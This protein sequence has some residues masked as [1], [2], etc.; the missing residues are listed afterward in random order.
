ML[1]L[2]DL[3]VEGITTIASSVSYILETPQVDTLY[4]ASMAI[5]I[6][7]IGVYFVW[8][9]L[10]MLSEFDYQ[11][12]PWLKIIKDVL[13]AFLFLFS[14]P[15][16]FDVVLEMTTVILEGLNNMGEVSV[17]MGGQLL[18]ISISSSEISG[19]KEC[20]AKVTDPNSSMYWLND[21]FN[22]TQACGTGSDTTRW[23][24]DYIQYWI[25][26][27]FGAVNLG[28][29]LVCSITAAVNS[30]YLMVFY[31]IAP[32]W[33][34]DLLTNDKQRFK[35]WKQYT[36][37]YTFATGLMIFALNIGLLFVSSFLDGDSGTSWFVL[38]PML[39][40]VLIFAL[41]SGK[42]LGQFFGS[43]ASAAAGFQAIT[44]MIST[45]GSIA[46]APGNI[47]SG[48]GHAAVGAAVLGAATAG[49]ATNSVSSGA[50]GARAGISAT[51]GADSP[52]SGFGATAMA[53]AGGAVSGAASGLGQGVGN[54]MSGSAAANEIRGA[55]GNSQS[56]AANYGTRG[57]TG[58][59]G[60]GFSAGGS[61]AGFS[62]GTTG[63]AFS[64]GT[65]TDTPP[66]PI[67]PQGVR[68]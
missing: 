39:A 37:F 56:S 49:V 62:A 60:A 64:A 54:T 26:W 61:G 19:A 55:F 4:Q 46:S 32:I 20:A 63:E 40:G 43:D 16:I 53:A 8:N 24:S 58:G 36:L 5:G 2:M 35:T 29:L 48:V 25:L 65:T 57:S 52:V 59:A 38:L 17:S 10:K 44:T 6:S 47:A 18:G 21:G 27:I 23:I 66:N 7:L 11:D 41:T 33:A 22:V 50:A 12:I 30:M 9:V 3:I 15:I 45:G 51:K 68:S 67:R 28:L 42:I 31:I 1:V 13:L 34:F 14:I